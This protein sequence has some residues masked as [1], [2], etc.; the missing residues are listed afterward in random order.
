MPRKK[1]LAEIMLRKSEIQKEIV[2][3]LTEQRIAELNTEVDALISEENQ[4]RGELDLASRLIVTPEEN[5]GG[6]G[7]SEAEKRGKDLREKRA[8][9][10]SSG[11]I[12][13]PTKVQNQLNELI[14]S[15]NSLV[16]KVKVTNCYGMGSYKVPYIKSVGTADKTGEGQDAGGTE[17]TFGYATL[18]PVKL[19]TYAEI[20]DETTKLS[21]V[22]YYAAV[23]SAARQALRKKLAEHMVNSDAL[24]SPDFIGIKD[25]T[26]IDSASDISLKVIDE[27]TLRTI[28]LNY[29][30]ADDV[31][32]EGILVLNKKDL[33]AFGDIR[34]TDK[35]P[36]YEITPD[37]ANTNTGIIRDGGLAVR[38]VL[39]SNITDM[40][41]A[42]TGN[43]TMFY[44][45]PTCY[46]LGLFSDYTVKVSED[47]EFKK[48]MLAVRGT[49]MAGGNV[50]VYNG[51]IRVKKASAT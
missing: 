30:G 3:G 50:T 27:K 26:T 12:A 6:E 9:L 19:T 29:G 18:K 48:D 38:Y 36:V 24:S 43:Y 4:I 40:A 28:A 39:N 44:G 32:G 31:V 13:T 2:A 51:F 22:D 37:T 45:V 42:S 11:S 33:I 20:S 1:R 21:D 8:V 10:V 16:D 7:E 15:G 49:V 47:A 41:S 17:P 35:K 46:E 34:G 25:S 14:G 5:H 23:Q